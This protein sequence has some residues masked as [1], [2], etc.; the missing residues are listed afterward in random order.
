MAILAA[1][2]I[3]KLSRTKG[4]I[5]PFVERGQ[6][7]G[8]TYG[9]GPCTYDFRIRQSFTLK[10]GGFVLA[11]TIEHVD[12]PHD[13]CGHVMDKSSWARRGL[14]V[15]NTKF[16][17]GFDGYCTLELKNHGYLPLEFHEGMPIM[18]MKFEVLVAKTD[19]P[20]VGRY[21]GQPDEPVPYRKAKGT[22]T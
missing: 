14:S 4:L 1:Q 13:L 15:F 10:P 3:R 17:P 8:M 9:L 5:T 22:W 2:H 7:H 21:K 19:L 18:Q 12:L 6:S 16:D 20:Y 11:S